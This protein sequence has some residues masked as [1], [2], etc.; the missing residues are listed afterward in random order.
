MLLQ[1]LRPLFL[2]MCV[3]VCVCVGG[4]GWGWGGQAECCWVLPG[5]C[6]AYKHRM[7]LPV[8]RTAHLELAASPLEL[9]C[10]SI[11][12]PCCPVRDVLATPAW[13][14]VLCHTGFH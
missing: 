13:P 10:N 9:L 3:C 6:A 11:K 1:Q 8:R 2:Q 14:V 12:V 4:G 7:Y 5:S